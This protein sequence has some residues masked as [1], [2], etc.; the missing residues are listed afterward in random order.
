NPSLSV[1]FPDG[2][3]GS[4][5]ICIC[6]RTDLQTAGNAVSCGASPTTAQLFWNA[7]P[8]AGITY[9]FACFVHGR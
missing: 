9:G 1:T 2:T 7:T 5:P 4:S 3:Y 8:A 6:G